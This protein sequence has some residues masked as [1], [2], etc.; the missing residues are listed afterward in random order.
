MVE[1]V[2]KVAVSEVGMCLPLIREFAMIAYKTEADEDKLTALLERAADQGTLF[3]YTIDDIPMG[4]IGGL[5]V[6]HP[7]MDY[8][9]LS[10]LVWYC[11]PRTGGGI[12]LIRAF[13]K[14]ADDLG[15]SVVLST[16]GQPDTSRAD[17]ILTTIGYTQT[18]KVWIK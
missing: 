1:T 15:L 17:K 5:I 10:E 6:D 4:V 9:V 3:V 11:R 14:R 12:P 8:R 18:E 13:E 7:F 2:H 16:L